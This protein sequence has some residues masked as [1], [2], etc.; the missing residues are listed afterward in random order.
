MIPFSWDQGSV[1]SLANDS[2]SM[3][4]PYI[5]WCYLQRVADAIMRRRSGISSSCLLGSWFLVLATLAF[6]PLA[7]GEIEQTATFLTI[8][9]FA[10]AVNIPMMA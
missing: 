5:P 3:K 2:G 8:D 4:R 6:E 7:G 10:D 9:L 1:V